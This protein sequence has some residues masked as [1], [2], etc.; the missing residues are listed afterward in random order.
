MGRID[1]EM[2]PDWRR[3]TARPPQYRAALNI[4]A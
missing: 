2:T 4:T 1:D 3:I